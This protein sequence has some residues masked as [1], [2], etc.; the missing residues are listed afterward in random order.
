MVR[1]LK[2]EGWNCNQFELAERRSGLTLDIINGY[3]GRKDLN[4]N[5]DSLG[6]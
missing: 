2:T 3:T 4:L 1:T 5:L 6:K